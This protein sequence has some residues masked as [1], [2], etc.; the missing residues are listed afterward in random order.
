[1]APLLL[2][3]PAVEDAAAT[4]SQQLPSLRVLPKPSS[5]DF[6][7]ESITGFITAAAVAAPAATTAA[8]CG[9]HGGATLGSTPGFPTNGTATTRSPPAP[10]PLLADRRPDQVLLPPLSTTT[11]LG[12]PAAWKA[13]TAATA[14]AAAA[15]MGPPLGPAPPADAELHV[16]L[17]APLPTLLLLPAPLA[18][19]PEELERPTLP[20]LLPTLPPPPTL[21]S[22]PLLVPPP[23]LEVRPCRSAAVWLAHL[24]S[25]V[26]RGGEGRGLCQ[27]SEA[28]RQRRFAAACRS[29]KQLA[30]C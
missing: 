2:L 12:C 1:M 13:A 28:L 15:S 3:L 6:P 10:P 16:L 4:A 29:Q 26:G 23:G 30:N 25:E 24:H 17:I 7:G 5:G 18:P 21:P 11:G 14:A 8:G 19:P 9:R 22:P 20:P 27:Q